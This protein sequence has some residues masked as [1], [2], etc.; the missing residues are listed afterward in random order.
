MLTLP[1]LGTLA[2]AAS[3]QEESAPPPPLE[4][5][6]HARLTEALHALADAHAERV[7]TVMIGRSRAGRALEGLRIAGQGADGPG[8]PAILLVANLEGPRV[9]ASA[10]ALQHARALAEGYE[11]DARVSALLDS[12]TV[13]VVP[14]ANPDAAEARFAEPRMEQHASGPGVDDDRDGRT[15][16][17]PRQDVDGDGVVTTI[18]VA[19]PDGEWRTDPTDARALVKADRSKG[20]SA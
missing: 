4:L 16:E 17:D 5:L 11:S 14:R 8:R 13:F 7:E 9:Y 10:V 3:V 6:D 12:T 1:L 2:L 15:G 18:R 19:D 20:R